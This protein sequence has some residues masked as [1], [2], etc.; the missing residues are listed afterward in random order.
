VIIDCAQAEDKERKKEADE[1]RKFAH[2]HSR[3]KAHGNSAQ[4]ETR[5]L[6]R[7]KSQ[8]M[9]VKS[10]CCKQLFEMQSDALKL[11]GGARLTL[12]ASYIFGFYQVWEAGTSLKEVFEDLQHLLEN[13]TEALSLAIEESIIPMGLAGVG[14]PRVD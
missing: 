4:L 2:Y 14:E 8:D 5:L 3:H 1:R 10:D 9:S 12:R 13:R 7:H 6:T 11:L